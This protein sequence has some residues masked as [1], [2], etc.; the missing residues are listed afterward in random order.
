MDEIAGHIDSVLRAIGTPQQ[1]AV[2]GAVK[3]R[4]ISFM[5]RFPLPYKL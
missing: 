2:V 3:A 5:A 4:V 1:D